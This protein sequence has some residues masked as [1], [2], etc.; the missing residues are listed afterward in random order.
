MPDMIIRKTRHRE[1]R[2]IV[3]VLEPDPHA[4]L[5]VLCFRGRFLEVLREE[6]LLGVEVVGCA[7]YLLFTESVFV[8]ESQGMGKG[9]GE[10]GRRLRETLE[11]RGDVRHQ[12]KYPR[13]HPSTS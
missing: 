9:R 6:L 5:P 2:M 8:I 3:P 10:E 11:R 4:P 12:S 13:A 1:I 7:L